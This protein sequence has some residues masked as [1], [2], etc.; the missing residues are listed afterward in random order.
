[1]DAAGVNCGEL[2]A[3]SEARYITGVNLNVNAGNLM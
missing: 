1:M 3:S 2:F